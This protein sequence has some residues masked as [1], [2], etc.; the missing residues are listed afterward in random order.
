MKRLCVVLLMCFLSSTVFA[1]NDFK[2]GNVGNWSQAD[3]W[4]AGYVPTGEEEV[5]VRS[6]G[7]ICTLNTGTGDWGTGQ[8]LRV[9]EDAKLI[10]E[11]GAELLGA[12]WMRVGAG[13]AG[14]VEQ[15]GG[16]LRL[17]AGKDTAKLGIG[18]S[19][20]SDGHYTISG[21]AI[22]YLDNEEKP[23]GQLIIGARGGQ[24][25]LTIIGT[26]ASIQM[27]TL[28]VGDGTGASG[29][30]EFQVDAAGVSPISLD[31]SASIDP[32]GDETTAALLVRAIGEPLMADI[33]LVDLPD[34]ANSANAFDTVN[35]EPALEGA[36]VILSLEGG[37]YYYNLTYVG[38]AGNDIVLTFDSFV[39]IDMEIGFT[40][41]PPVLDGQVDK[42]WAGASTQY[43]VP[44]DDPAN[45][46]GSWMALY[47]SDNLYII[48]DIT[49]DSLQND[50]DGSWQD[51]SVEVYFDGG[52]TKLSTPLAGDDHQYTFGWT[53]EEIQGTN[54][55][56]YTDGIEHAQVDTETG[57]R[58]EIKMPWLSIQGAAPQ[59]GDLIGIDVYYNDDD[60]G[61]DSRENKM[62]G[63]SAI[64]GWNDA[65][66]WGTAILAAEPKPVDPGTDGLV[67]HY[68]FEN[69]A[70]DSSGNGHDGTIEGDPQ[71][72]AGRSGQALKFDGT[73]DYV[74]IG[75]GAGD[76]F[77]TLNSG[78]TVAAWISRAS[79]GTYDIIFGAGRNPVGT[80]VG[81][82][83]NGWKFGIDSGDVIKFT[84]LGILDYT[85]SVG[86]PVDEWVHVAATFNEAGTEVQIYLNGNLEDTISG[87]G[88]ANPATGLYAVGFGGTWELEFF[89]GMLD[90]VMIYNRSL[91]EGEIRY[92]AGFRV[93]VE[94]VHSYTF[95]DGTGNDCIGQADGVLVGD[96]A[97]VDGSLVVDGDGDWMEMPGDVIAINTYSEM[98]LEL[99][100]TQS[101]DNP[102]SM[103]ASFGGTWDNGMGKDYICICTGRGDQMNRGSIANTPDEVNPWEDEVGVSSP[104]L[105]DGIEHHYVLT[106]TAAELAYYVDGVLIGTAPMGETTISGLS[107]DFV[108]LGKGIYGVDPTMNCSINEFNIYDAAISDKQIADNYAAGP[109]K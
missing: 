59:A 28:I 40:T 52:N 90:D 29:T 102:F 79:E 9:Y 68:A 101:V 57:W 70:N 11:E 4:S 42:T 23:G 49:D 32:E 89:D 83:N 69:D 81:D 21:G 6:E 74:N 24:G 73:E 82:D 98:T 3:L 17:T 39:K 18:D 109:A 5:K 61:G 8:R 51:D 10:I 46:S 53:T 12:G 41:Q 62:L 75:L 35:G 37:N 20:G 65:S 86:V 106:I 85:S 19:G 78:F 66:Q 50:S 91:S 25:I 47:D 95:E 103:T 108:F 84:T 76:Y 63:F 80:A 92:L 36:S 38:G 45:G 67:A 14:Y 105:N 22:T 58:I 1:S 13:D 31:D 16:L 54:I 104:E 97:I 93:P 96:A 60:D 64:E 48:V 44:L 34:D 94:P 71:W 33:L 7:T 72:V 15:T 43:F 77:A 99:W 107:N 2:D 87:N 56:G 30:L 55:A 100:S 27:D 26:G 88:P